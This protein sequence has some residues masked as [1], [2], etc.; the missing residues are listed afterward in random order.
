MEPLLFFAGFVAI[1]VGRVALRVY[2]DRSLTDGGRPVARTVALIVAVSLVVPVAVAL[3]FVFRGQVL[4]AAALVVAAG[5]SV[6]LQLAWMR[7][8]VRDAHR[9]A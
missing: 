5:V 1:A 3:A 2:V 8:V 4:P 7:S 9:G 6:L